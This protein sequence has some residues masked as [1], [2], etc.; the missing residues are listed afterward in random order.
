MNLE[1]LIPQPLY[2]SKWFRLALAIVVVLVLIIIIVPLAIV[3]PRQKSKKPGA[4]II[5]PLYIYPVDNSS[6]VPVHDA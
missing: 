6:W 1:K 2:R 5:L 4:S 3:L